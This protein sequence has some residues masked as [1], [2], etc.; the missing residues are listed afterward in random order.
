MARIEVA[1]HV[2]APPGRVWAALV[3]WE[4]QRRWRSGVR[5][6]TVRGDQREGVGTTLRYRLRAPVIDRDIKV[7]VTDWEPPQRL[8]ARCEGVLAG[9][10]GAFELSETAHG[11]LVSWWRE[12]DAPLDGL[13]EAVGTVLVVPAARRAARHS[14]ARL[15]ARAEAG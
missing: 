5:S 10:V 3:D 8:G 1:T 14:L 11:T 9:G 13:G 7:M 4:G 12:I 2:E 15:K 6:V